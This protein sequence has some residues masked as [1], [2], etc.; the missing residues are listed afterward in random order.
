MR[1][2][3]GPG[4][5]DATKRGIAEPV[6]SRFGYERLLSLERP[7]SLEVVDTYRK[8]D[9]WAACRQTPLK[10]GHSFGA[11]R[12]CASE[13]KKVNAMEESATYSPFPSG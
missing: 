8:S 7:L 12:L 2:I 11:I 10:M 13:K 5:V 3:A 1:A 4:G 9:R 6:S